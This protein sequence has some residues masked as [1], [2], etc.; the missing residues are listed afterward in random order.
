MCL[1]NLQS[2]EYLTSSRDE[3]AKLKN[4]VGSWNTCGKGAIRI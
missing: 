4:T 3:V 1:E 2:T